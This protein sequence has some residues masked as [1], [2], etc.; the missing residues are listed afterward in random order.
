[1]EMNLSVEKALVVEIA[2]FEAFFKVHYTKGA[3]LS[4]H[5]PLP[6]SVAG[7]FG[8]MLGWNRAA[9]G[10]LGEANGLLF[11]SKMLF[12]KGIV[13]EEATYIEAPKNIRGVAPISLV[14]EPSY[15]VAMAG[16]EVV[17]HK[18]QKQLLIGYSYLPY[19]GQNDFFVKEINIVGFQDVKP[20]K[21]IENYAPKDFVER[22]ELEKGASLHTLPVVHRYE[23]VD[24]TFYFV[25]G[26]G[27]IILKSE[28]PCV[29][30]IGL[31]P[32]SDFY[33]VVG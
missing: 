10:C 22:V 30:G 8:A 20:S 24:S 29:N 23:G 33:W 19:C 3:R 11:G 2:F 13:T 1:M 21:E 4:Y 12:S 31:Y 28:I 27:K 14:N 15:L 32:I 18:Y 16:E 17:I 6:T 9:E 5:M 26:G 7:I 25:S